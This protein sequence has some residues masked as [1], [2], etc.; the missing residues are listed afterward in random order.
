MSNINVTDSSLIKVITI[1]E[2]GPRGPAGLSGTANTVI[3]AGD[4]LSGGGPLT[5]NVTVQ[6]DNTVMRVGNVLWIDEANTRVGINQT[7]PKIDLH[8]GSTGIG[9][10]VSH[11]TSN[12]P[13]QIIDTWN[14]L[15]IRSAK[16]QMQIYSNSA[17]HYEISEI[18]LL[19]NDNEVF[20]TEYAIINQG[21]RL[22]QFSASIIN[23]EVR[24]L[25]SPTYAVNEIKVVRTVIME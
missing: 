8:I 14:A 11:T 4:G 10:Y 25:C 17:S 18:F 6:V 9:S 1:A 23:N 16:Y 21:T 5:G 13:N 20:M 19:H 15:D 12:I 7:N 3:I 24:L 22:A 2:Q